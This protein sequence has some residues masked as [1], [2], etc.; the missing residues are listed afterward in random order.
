VAARHEYG[1]ESSAAA[2]EATPAKRRAALTS[3]M[4]VWPSDYQ[5]KLL[6][7]LA[8]NV[9]SFSRRKSKSHTRRHDAPQLGLGRRRGQRRA[10]LEQLHARHAASFFESAPRRPVPLPAL[11]ARRRGRTT[12]QQCRVGEPRGSNAAWVAAPNN[13][14]APWGVLVP[15]DNTPG[16]GPS[17]M[18]P[19]FRQW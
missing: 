15:T 17:F 5:T 11:F 18:G 4:F 7:P 1:H 9:W 12:R 16:P 19:F 10:P 3:P 6:F 13:N 14:S 8:G 2:S